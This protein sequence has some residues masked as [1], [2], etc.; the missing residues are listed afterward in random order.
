MAKVTIT[1][2]ADRVANFLNA[3][4]DARQLLMD[5]ERIEA[6]YGIGHRRK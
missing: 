1:L 2:D 4:A 5:V 6:E 3:I